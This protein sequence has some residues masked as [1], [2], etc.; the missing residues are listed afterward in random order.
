MGV[1]SGTGGDAQGDILYWMENAWGGSGDDTL[2][3][4]SGNNF[5]DGSVGNDTLKGEGGNDDLK[6][7]TGE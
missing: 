2:T 5:L 1:T 4:N 6:A 3:G 7:W